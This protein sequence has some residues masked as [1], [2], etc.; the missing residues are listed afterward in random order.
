MDHAGLNVEYMYAFVEKNMDQAII[1]FHFDDIDKAI[2][3]LE[4]KRKYW[5]VKDF[6]VR[7]ENHL[8]ASYVMPKELMK[9]AN[10]H[11]CNVW[12][13]IECIRTIKELKEGD[14]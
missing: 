7:P 12:T 2:K 1:L 14:L 3:D 5:D 9:M 8:R 6:D 4:R 13:L 11:D 10:E